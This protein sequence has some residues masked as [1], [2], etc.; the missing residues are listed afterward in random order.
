MKRAAFL[1]LAS[2]LMLAFA[3][4]QDA[5]PLSQ[6]ELLKTLDGLGEGD[7]RTKQPLGIGDDRPVK[8]AEAAPKKQKGPTEITANAL[9]FD[10]KTNLAIFSGEVEVKDPEFNVKCD[11]LTATLAAKNGS[12]K[13]GSDKP[14][15]PSP[16]SPPEKNPK[17]DKGGGLEKAVAKG[18]VFIVQETTGSDGKISRNTG[19]AEMA[20]YDAVSGEITLSGWPEAT[21]G[22]NTCVALEAGTKLILT[23]AGKM[24]TEGKAKF[25]VQDSPEK[26]P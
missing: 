7:P 10:Q 15:S 3:Q 19:K 8:R 16:G 13:A 17:K 18:N 20:V 12:A 24:R 11:E 6:D 5:K 23:R 26:K 9:D 21:Q 1:G 4:A 2:G 22:I 25:V 14:A